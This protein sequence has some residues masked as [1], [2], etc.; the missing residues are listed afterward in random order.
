LPENSIRDALTVHWRASADALRTHHPGRPLGFKVRRVVGNGEL[1]ITEYMID[2]QGRS[3]YTV[4]YFADP[5]E[6]PA[7]RSQWVERIPA[8]GDLNAT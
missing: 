7:W 2:Y 6:V 3:A 4:Q 1:W 8:Q 5:F